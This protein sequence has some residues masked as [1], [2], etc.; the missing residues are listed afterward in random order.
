MWALNYVTQNVLSIY[1]IQIGQLVW[2]WVNFFNILRSTFM[3][4]VP[5]STKWH[6]WFEFSVWQTAEQIWWK[7]CQF[8]L[9]IWSFNCW[10]NQTENFLC[11]CDFSLG[12]KSLFKLTPDIFLSKRH[13]DS[14]LFDL[15]SA[16]TS[17]HSFLYIPF[18]QPRLKL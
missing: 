15:S 14:F 1:Q 5:K 2:P 17:M 9:E 7:V 8:K 6:W 12:K 3:C 13:F 10:W 18:N 4:G 11:A 16:F